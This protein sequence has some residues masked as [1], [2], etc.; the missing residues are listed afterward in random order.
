MNITRRN[1]VRQ[2]GRWCFAG[3]VTPAITSM[4]SP[5]IRE[6]LM[7][8]D[9]DI[10]HAAD[11]EIR[12]NRLLVPVIF[13]GVK[14]HIW[15]NNKIVALKD[16][17]CTLAFEKGENSIRFAGRKNGLK[18]YYADRLKK[19]YRVSIDDAIWFLRDIHQN[20]QRYPS[21]FDHP[22][23]AYFKT[24]HE[25]YGLKL[26]INLFYETE[27]F[28]LSQMTDRYR[29]EWQANADWIRLSIHA[30]SEFPDNPYRNAGYNDIKNDVTLVN[31]EIER[32][33]GRALMNRETTLH[34]GEVPVE[35]SRGLRDSG[36]TIQVCDFNVDNNLPPCSYY[37]TV[38]QRRHMNRRF[39]W[40]DNEEN[41]TFVRSAII[42]DTVKLQD[43][44]PFLNAYAG[45]QL[46]LPYVD[47]LIHEQ[48]FYDFYKNYQPDYT[49]KLD[50]CID[51]AV[52]NKYT[53]GFVNESLQW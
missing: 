6:G 37:L 18:V 9:G 7:L 41:I 39:V 8:V 2:A 44:T 20:Q 43:I 16:Q 26:H 31:R 52:E 4:M 48:Y 28:N 32:F 36:Y 51:W 46:F 14:D 1:F 40:R 13:P 12:N 11:G 3:A 23:L 21:I 29:D 47:F 42:V 45:K 19:Q 25:Q 53:P 24:R 33:A 17:Q 15:H 27:G 22:F 34:W 10:V 35:V 49:R 38:P 50:A 5:R 30:K